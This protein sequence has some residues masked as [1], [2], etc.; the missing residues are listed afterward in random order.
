MR[1]R[2]GG[3][4]MPP[5]EDD[6]QDDQTGGG[7]NQAARSFAPV[8]LGKLE[9]DKIHHRARLVRE[10]R[11][12]AKFFGLPQFLVQRGHELG[13]IQLQQRAISADEPADVNRRGKNV[14]IPLLQRADV[15][16]PDFCDFG[17]LINREAFCLARQM[18]LF[19]NRGHSATFLAFL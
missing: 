13:D 4:M 9:G 19:R 3:L 8:D 11:R 10:R 7:N 18:E 1:Q 16:R 5:D 14:E 17:H 15:V 2:I 12:L 6:D